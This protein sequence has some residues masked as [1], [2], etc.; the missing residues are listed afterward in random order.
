MSAKRALP[1]KHPTPVAAGRILNLRPRILVADD[2][3]NF[4]GVTVTTLRHAGY[5]VDMAEDGVLAWDA[6]K[7]N[8]YDLLITDHNMPMMTGL[9]LLKRIR[10]ARLAVP[11]IL[12]SGDPPWAELRRNPALR[13][14]AILLKPF[15]L[16]ELSATVNQVLFAPEGNI[17]EG[18]SLTNWQSPPVTED[19][20]R[21]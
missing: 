15:S 5:Q 9:T 1:C 18:A 17:V 7:A 4:L 11:A 3:P 12:M 21:S 19:L 2:E 20:R 16:G 8:S 6:L 13:I 14:A 10:A